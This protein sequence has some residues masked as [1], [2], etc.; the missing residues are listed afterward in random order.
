MV[1][2]QTDQSLTGLMG[3]ETPEAPATDELAPP[4]DTQDTEETAPDWEAKA[5]EAEA[6][7]DASDKARIKAETDLKA[8]KGRVAKQ[9]DL[10]ATLQTLTEQANNTQGLVEILI[11]GVV[12]SDT[13][14]VTEALAKHRERTQ[15]AGV[16]KTFQDSYNK[17]LNRLLKKNEPVEGSPVI[18]DI[19]T[20]PSFEQIR[21]DWNKALATAQTTGSFD[22]LDDVLEAASEIITGV[23]LS[24]STEKPTGKTE[25][26]D[27]TPS[28]EKNPYDMGVP[29][30]GAP[31][32]NS[33]VDR[34]SPNEKIAEGLRKKAKAISTN[35]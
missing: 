10:S 21:Q 28:T 4:S 34:M 25:D 19:Y 18:K 5:K 15:A 30:G 23:R 3:L 35:N 32:G 13:E 9:T 27:N 14:K 2:Q 26:E 7:A 31:A 24:Q 33:R 17:R 22:D 29:R 6:K 16:T 1:E 8:E 12:D 20:D 11:E